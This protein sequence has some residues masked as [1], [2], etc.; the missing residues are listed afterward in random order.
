MN[1]I[2]HISST[3]VVQGDVAFAIQKA[4]LTDKLCAIQPEEFHQLVPGNVSNKAELLALF[5]LDQSNKKQN[6]TTPKQIVEQKAFLSGLTDLMEALTDASVDATKNGSHLRSILSQGTQDGN[7]VLSKAAL[8]NEELK[9]KS[10]DEQKQTAGM[11]WFMKALA[12]TGAAIMAV[13]SVVTGNVIGAVMIVGATVTSALVTEIKNKDGKSAIDLFAEC[14]GMNPTTATLTIDALII[15]LSMGAGA[16]SAL[17][18]TTA[19]TVAEEGLMTAAKRASQGGLNRAAQESAE[20]EMTVMSKSA[21]TEVTTVAGA[22]AE[23]LSGTVRS[24]LDDVAENVA[25]KFAKEAE[26]RAHQETEKLLEKVSLQAAKDGTQ[27]TMSRQALAESKKVVEEGTKALDQ[28]V[29]DGVIAGFKFGVTESLNSFSPLGHGFADIEYALKVKS[30]M[31]DKEKQDLR[32]ECEAH[33]AYFAAATGL[34]F[35]VASLKFTNLSG[36]SYF[37]GNPLFN[38]GVA[39]QRVL[40]GVNGAVDGLKL[41]GTGV[42]SAFLVQNANT[43]REMAENQKGVDL[44][45][46]TAQTMLSTQDKIQEQTKNNVDA[47]NEAYATAMQSIKEVFSKV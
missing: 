22:T 39:V 30:T 15:A 19:T 36:L 21:A 20:I 6:V 45:Q 7:A 17:G 38:N 11:Q 46:F 14:K 10:V 13:G 24:V 34:M 35:N 4:D 3:T 1:P 26:S 37:Q 40:A 43:I 42:M 28:L 27:K 32:D 12:W 18:K 8:H 25:K 47:L 41:I 44:L 29:K 5:G 2:E 16:A 31:S 33:G 23:S 9:E